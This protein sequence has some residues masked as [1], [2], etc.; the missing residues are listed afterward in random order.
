MDKSY[1][2]RIYFLAIDRVTQEQWDQKDLLVCL[3]L[4][5]LPDNQEDL[6]QWEQEAHEETKELQ[7]TLDL[8]E[9]QVVW[10]PQVHLEHLDKWEHRE[11]L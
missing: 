11:F 6:D 10:A 4:G 7:A 1:I 9:S 8:Q 3:E 2:D 5:G